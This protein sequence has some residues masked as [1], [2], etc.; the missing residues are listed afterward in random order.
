MN[1][2]EPKFLSQAKQEEAKG[3]TVKQLSGEK[4]INLHLTPA[5]QDV[6]A[7]HSAEQQNSFLM[8]ILSKTNKAPRPRPKLFRALG[9]NEPPQTVKIN[10]QIY[11]LQEIIKHDSWAATAIYAN[12][13][14]KIICK[15]NRQEPIFGIPMQWLGNWLAAR[16]NYVMQVFHDCPHT[17]NHSGDVYVNDQIFKNISAHEYLTA[18]PLR[19]Y[20]PK[21][22]DDFFAKLGDIL[23]ILHRN[24]IAY[25]D[26]NKPENILVAPNG[27]PILIDFQICFILSKRW[28]WN[29]KLMRSALQVFQKTDLYHLLK[30]RK[31]FRPDQL[32]AEELAESECRPWFV[33]MFR[34]I[35]TPIRIV[36][37]KLLVLLGIRNKTGKAASE[38]FVEEALR[39]E[40]KHYQCAEVEN[41]KIIYTH[42]LQENTLH[43]L[44]VL[45]N[46]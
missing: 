2:I 39:E 18:T 22:N 25:L 4:S 23:A 33:R 15:F 44:L 27:D 20:Q 37:R 10:A 17:P 40:D 5:A 34:C 12:P 31:Y 1:V 46:S 24:N 11:T 19:N 3:F 6:L 9:N 35:F 8:A 32:T 21:L 7:T 14:E 43:V 26:F 16:E 41:Y 42:N 30:H 38:S 28:P 13:A 36:R 45:K 29:G